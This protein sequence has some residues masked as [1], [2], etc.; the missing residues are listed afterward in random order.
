MPHDTACEWARG[1]HGHAALAMANMHGG[2]E[3]RPRSTA[4]LDR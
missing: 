3:W 1:Q 4:Q 2:A